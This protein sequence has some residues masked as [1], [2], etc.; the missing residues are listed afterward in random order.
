[1]E[2]HTER[3]T[4]RTWRP[5]DREPFAALNAD[6]VAMEHFPSTMTRA[7]SDAFANRIDARLRERGWGLWAVEVDGVADFVGFVGLNDVRF[8]APFSPAV[9]IGWR[10]LSEHWGHGYATEAARAAM[11]HGF[12]ELDLAEIVSFTVP[13]N[14][15]SRR[16]M[17]KLGMTHSPDD[18]FDHPLLAEGHPLRWH[19]LYRLRRAD[20]VR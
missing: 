10:L 6:P 1:M 19:V 16:V 5:A 4:L 7:E 11:A 3:L 15:R 12:D 14:L 9:E 13:A 2:L 18:D 20:F 8:D 17:E